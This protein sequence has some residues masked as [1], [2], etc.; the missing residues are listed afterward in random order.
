MIPI[1]DI[2]APVSA[3]LVAGI[4]GWFSAY[5]H[6]KKVEAERVAKAAE[7]RALEAAAEREDTAKIRLAEFQRDGDIRLQLERLWVATDKARR[8]CERERE[9]CRSEMAAVR[10]EHATCH[11]TIAA[12]EER[13]ARVERVTGSDPPP[14]PRRRR[15]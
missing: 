9:K 6:A 13:L 3:V 4:S 2:A 12:L 14:P 7:A 1:A 10:A 8:E 15:I 5:V 11:T